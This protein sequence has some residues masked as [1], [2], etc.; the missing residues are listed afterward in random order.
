MQDTDLNNFGQMYNGLEDRIDGLEKAKVKSDILDPQSADVKRDDLDARLRQIEDQL[1]PYDEYYSKVKDA[2]QQ[3][4]NVEARLQALATAKAESE[5]SLSKQVA[6]QEE[7]IKALSVQV[8]TTSDGLEAASPSQLSTRELA[9]TLLRRLQRGDTLNSEIAADLSALLQ[10]GLDG[11]VSSAL[12]QASRALETPVTD[13]A[14][15]RRSISEEDEPPT[16]RARKRQ[17]PQAKSCVKSVEHA[18]KTPTTASRRTL[19]GAASDV[20]AD[21]DDRDVDMDDFDFPPEVRRTSR[22]SRPTQLPEDMVSWKDADK[23]MPR[24]RPG[25]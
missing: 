6:A 15:A 2:V 21:D 23:R 20:E 11:P 16:K 10:S 13:D 5:A 7:S 19:D 17:T 3:L 22:K 8:K 18:A 12:D 9:Q 14:S 1:K 4:H 25:A 24:M